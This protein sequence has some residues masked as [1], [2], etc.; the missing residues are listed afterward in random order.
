[1]SKIIVGNAEGVQGIR[2]SLE[3]RLE[4]DLNPES[5]RDNYFVEV[6]GF[7]RLGKDY[8][9]K[10]FLGLI[11][12][13]TWAKNFTHKGSIIVVEQPE[14]GLSRSQKYIVM[15]S[16]LHLVHTG[17]DVVLETE[18]K[19]FVGLVQLLQSVKSNSEGVKTLMDILGV[20]YHER[21]WM[22]IFTEILRDCQ[23]SLASNTSEDKKEV[24][25]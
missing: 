17:R 13:L 7:N 23:V 24:V 16:I 25:T 10:P 4:H 12:Q 6:Y 11:H 22:Q 9:S 19:D 2:L 18:D 21:V 8:S 14:A 15:L 20:R 3:K 5:M 1:M